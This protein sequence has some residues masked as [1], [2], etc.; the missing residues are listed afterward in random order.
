METPNI[1]QLVK[2]LRV[3]MG[4]TQEQFANELGVTFSTINQ[5]ENGHRK[6]MPFLVKR[7]QEMDAATSRR[8]GK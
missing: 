6:P 7:L 3:R 4:L 1:P 8:A 2:N 5:W